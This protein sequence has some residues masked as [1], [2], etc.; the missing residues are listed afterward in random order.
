VDN[1]LIEI[2]AIALNATIK[3]SIL[4]LPDAFSVNDRIALGGTSQLLGI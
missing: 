4:A 3:G 2:S 1:G